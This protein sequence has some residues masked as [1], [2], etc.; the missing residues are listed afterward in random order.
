VDPHRFDANPDPDLGRHQ[1]GN[2]ESKRCRSTTLQVAI[3]AFQDLS[4]KK[5]YFGKESE[6]SSLIKT[7]AYLGHFLDRSGNTIDEN[8]G[9]LV[10]VGVLHDGSRSLRKP[11][12]RISVFLFFFLFFFVFFVFFFTYLPRR[13]SL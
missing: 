10:Q 13:D 8:G 7:E 11:V 4:R 1:N 5:G 3:P 9:Q 6:G 2:S 12:L